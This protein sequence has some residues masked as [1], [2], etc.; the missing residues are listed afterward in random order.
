MNA[1]D[2]SID[3]KALS[4]RFDAP[5]LSIGI[6]Q[7]DRT[8]GQIGKTF[9]REIRLE[10]ALQYG[11][12]NAATLRSW[13]HQD[14]TAKVLFEDLNK[15]TLPQALLDLGK[16]LPKTALVWANGASDDITKLEHAYAKTG[17]PIPW[18][19]WNIR[20][21]R[22]VVDLGA[23]A[24]GD[25]KFEGS[26]HN[27]LDEATHQAQV[28]AICTQRLGGK[29][30]GVQ[31]VGMPPPGRRSEMPPPGSVDDDDELM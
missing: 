27:A 19:D 21:M 31:T 28:I 12:V 2:Y 7:F 1:N 22:T 16:F 14:G 5:I 26:H 18:D 29:S 17:N 4:T 23:Y 3:L 25:I 30:K 6:A 9:Y 15:Y 20:D 24:T 13:M 10:S 8:N 11:A